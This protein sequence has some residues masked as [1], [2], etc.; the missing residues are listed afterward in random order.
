M[1]RRSFSKMTKPANQNYG[2]NV[3]QSNRRSRI[4]N[5][6]QIEPIST[7]ISRGESAFNNRYS[8][9]GVATTSLDQD[10][11]ICSTHWGRKIS[12]TTPGQGI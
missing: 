2:F 9:R 8:D 3:G 1:R 5:C 6:V 12:I 10:R 11:H 4:V 7:D